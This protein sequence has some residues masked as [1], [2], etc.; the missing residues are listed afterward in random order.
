MKEKE[1]GAA[2]RSIK[3]FEAPNWP[4]AQAHRNGYF[5]ALNSIKSLLN[6]DHQKNEHPR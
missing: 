1:A 3:A 6:L 5:L 4:F 2:E